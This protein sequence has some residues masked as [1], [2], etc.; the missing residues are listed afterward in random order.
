MRVPEVRLMLCLRDT[1]LHAL[2]TLPK[3]LPEILLNKPQ[4][5]QAVDMESWAAN[6]KQY[7]TLDSKCLCHEMMKRVR[8][9]YQLVNAWHEIPTLKELSQSFIKRGY[10][11]LSSS[12]E[13]QRKKK[14]DYILLHL[15]TFHV[16]NI[17]CVKL[18]QKLL[19]L[20][21]N[22]ITL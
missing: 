18:A 15:A 5:S 21:V 2:V 4:L 16:E 11:Y 14:S 20:K 7:I 22:T 17:L 9:L 19:M 6:L 12:E 8:G 13:T 1:L 3:A 10:C